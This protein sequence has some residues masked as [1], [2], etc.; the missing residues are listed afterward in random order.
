MA[1][2]AATAG[3]GRRA[4]PSFWRR[5]SGASATSR[6][7]GV[8]DPLRTLLAPGRA[9]LLTSAFPA[10]CASPACM[11]P[12]CLASLRLDLR[13]DGVC[14]PSALGCRELIRWTHAAE[15]P[16]A[17]MRPGAQSRYDASPCEGRCSLAVEGGCP[18][19]LPLS[20]GGQGRRTVDHLGEIEGDAWCFTRIAQGK[21]GSLSYGECLVDLMLPAG[22]RPGTGSDRC[23]PVTL[24]A[25]PGAG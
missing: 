20:Y 24:R 23:R 1:D 7:A 12:N 10:V 19:S 9:A 11:R 22:W 2:A 8:A 3:A 6:L 18:A 13:E 21:P 17:C 5:H 25:L 16:P 15:A 14:L 4:V